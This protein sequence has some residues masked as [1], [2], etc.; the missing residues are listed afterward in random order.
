MESRSA[1]L[2]NRVLKLGRM[3]E[4]S[5]TRSIM[6]LAK[7]DKHLAEAVIK[8]DEQIDRMEVELEEYCLTILEEDHPVGD[9]LRFVVA[10]LKINDTLERIGDLAENIAAAVRK[11][12]NWAIFG[13]VRGCNEMAQRSQTMLK[14]ALEALVNRDAKLARRVIEDDHRVNEMRSRLGKKIVHAIDTSDSSAP[15]LRLEF[16]TRQL[17]RIGDLATNIAEDVIFMIEGQIVRHPSRFDDDDVVRDGSG[18]RFRR[19]T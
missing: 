11:V 5:I 13:R 1:E 2:H 15:L 6:A 4:S 7:Q 8:E 3:V 19:V 16:V 17:E 10:V 12:E 9:E 14:R 18:G